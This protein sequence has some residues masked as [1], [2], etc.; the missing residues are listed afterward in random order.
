[1]ARCALAVSAAAA[2]VAAASAAVCAT[3]LDCSLNGLCVASQ[4]VC[5][6][7]WSGPACAQ[8]AYATTPALAKNIYRAAD[9]HNTWSGPIVGPGDDGKHHAFIPL[10]QVGSLWHVI[11]TMHGVAEAVT[12]PWDWSSQ[13]NISSAAINPGFLAF[14]NAS[15][16][17]T[18]FSLWTGGDI[19]TAESLYGPFTRAARYSG[20]N[21]SPVFLNGAFYLTTQA[22]R[23]VLTSPTLEGPWTFFANISHSPAQDYTVED[24]HM[25]VDRRGSWHIICHAYNTSEMADCGSSHVSAHFF[26]LDG[27]DWRWT[28][29]PYGHTVTYDDGTA[30]TYATLERPFL[31]FNAEGQPAFLSLAA[32]LAAVDRDCPAKECCACCK[33][34]DHAGTIVVALAV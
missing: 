29:Q 5:D 16:G 32:D 24:P 17:A 6:A 12:G 34:S 27:K 23:E 11:T 19:L 4:C 22:T 14:K 2:A 28:D 26:S 25:W 15:S 10:Y 9:A 18:V 13:P 31:S 33:F 1:M 30:L 21:P 20:T 3:D 8:L 7:P